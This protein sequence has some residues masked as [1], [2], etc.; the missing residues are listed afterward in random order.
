[1]RAFVALVLPLALRGFSSPSDRPAGV[2]AEPSGF[3]PSP[4]KDNYPDG[5]YARDDHEVG[6]V[7]E[8]LM[9]LRHLGTPGRVTDTDDELD[10]ISFSEIRESDATY[11]LLHTSAT[12]CATCRVEALYLSE[13]TQSIVEEGGAVIELV[14]DGQ[15]TGLDPSK[16]ELDVWVELSDLQVT[17]MGAG[18]DNLRKVFPTRDHVYII[19]LETMEVVWRIDGP[20]DGQAGSE[21]GAIELLSRYLAE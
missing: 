2:D 9:L 14:V 11:L 12:W 6:D 5:P 21:I 8:N 17:T 13:Y 3:I 16:E 4:T 20:K 1:M 19:D 15:A 7:V 10:R 18:D